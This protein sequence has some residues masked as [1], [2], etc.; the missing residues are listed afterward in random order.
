[1]NFINFDSMRNKHKRSHCHYCGAEGAS[2][3]T[4]EGN[5]V[6]YRC[7]Q[8]HLYYHYAGKYYTHKTQ[9]INPLTHPNLQIHK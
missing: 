6:W 7:S 5:R 2:T 1:M 3:G 8:G 9:E 4:V